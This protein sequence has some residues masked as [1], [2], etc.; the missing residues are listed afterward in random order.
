MLSLRHSTVAGDR[1]P[2]AARGLIHRL[3]AIDGYRISRVVGESSAAVVYLADDRRRG[4]KVALKVPK[5]AQDDHDAAWQ[6]FAFECDVVSSIRHEHVVRVVEHRVEN[7][8][9]YLAME[10]LRGGTLRER[11]R[12]PMSEAQA[13]RLLRQAAAGLAAVHRRAVVHR[14]VKP[15]N[16]LLRSP[17]VLALTDFGT[18]APVASNAS[19][20]ARG[21]L[22]GTPWYV[23][24]EQAEGA[25]P[26]TAA[27]VYSLGVVLHEMLC[28]RRPFPG[29]TAQEVL[30]QHL[31]APVPRMPEALAHCQ[32]LIDRMLEKCPHRRLPD[33]DAV[34]QELRRVESDAIA[35]VP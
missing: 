20:A 27:D 28:G 16:F 25:K 11:M 19:C 30:A 21:H 32:P 26:G 23:A 15:E 18:A 29:Q 2:A 5:V 4:G 24:P 3:R 17:G 13:L 9:G 8:L 6:R 22:T 31:V 12:S 14:D 35:G 34:L 1:P 7:G 33:A 10:Y